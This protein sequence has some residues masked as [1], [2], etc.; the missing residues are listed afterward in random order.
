MVVELAQQTVTRSHVLDWSGRLLL[1]AGLVLG[2]LLALRLAREEMDQRVLSTSPY[3][4]AASTPQFSLPPATALPTM[5]PTATPTAPPT[6]QPTAKPP[7]LPALRI[8]IPVIRLNS[9]I[10][11]ITPSSKVRY[12]QQRFIWDP[13]P[14]V[15][16][17]YYSSGNPGD[18]TNIVLSGHNNTLGEVFRSL[19][20]LGPGDEV[21]L[22]TEG[23]EYQYQVE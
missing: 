19:D 2:C 22:F 1:S 11:D 12:G 23:G 14:Y 4:M 9:S 13:L 3:L 10:S 7:S 5:T 17:H 6:A 20:Q 18:G 21:I 15:V 16:A 8:S